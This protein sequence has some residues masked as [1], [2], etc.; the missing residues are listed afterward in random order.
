MRTVAVTRAYGLGSWT[1]TW[2]LLEKPGP[3]KAKL[4]TNVDK[5]R[6]RQTRKKDNIRVTA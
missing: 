4:T 6:Q 2:G 3:Y 5:I 1:P